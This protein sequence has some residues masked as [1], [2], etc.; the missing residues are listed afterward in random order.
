[1]TAN[2]YSRIEK[3]ITYLAE[4]YRAQPSLNAV[5]RRVHLSPFHFQRLFR[6]FAGISP[7]RFVQVLTADYARAQLAF[8][9]NVL[10]ASHATGLSGAGRLHDLMVNLH[11][12][13]PGEIRAQGKGLVI[14]YGFHAT[15]FGDCLVALSQHGVCALR[16]VSAKERAVELRTLRAEWPL[17][18]YRFAPERTQKITTRLFDGSRSRAFNLYVKGTNFQVKVWEALLRLPLGNVT[19]YETV[20]RAVGRNRA[21]RAVASAIA[22]NPVAW[23]IPCHRV[24]RKSGALGGYRWG[25]ARKQT[26]LAWETVRKKEKPSRK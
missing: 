19:S 26:L 15:L 5:A 25:V 13:T 2:D 17:A 18:Q 16:F 1:M 3:A 9:S 4:N 21:V 11:A 14:H 20:A 7:K 22:R 24:I 8:S 12:A 6:R 10:D 23:L